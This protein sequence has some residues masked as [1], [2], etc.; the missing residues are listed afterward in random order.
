M[1]GRYPS[2][3]IELKRIARRDARVSSATTLV[4]PSLRS[5]P[6]ATSPALQHGVDK[7]SADAELAR[8]LADVPVAAEECLT[9]PAIV[10]SA[11]LPVQRSSWCSVEPQGREASG[12]PPRS[13]AVE[14]GEEA[15]LA[16]Q[17]HD[18]G[19][20]LRWD[21]DAQDGT[22]TFR[23]S[24]IEGDHPV[25]CNRLCDD[26]ARDG[27]R[28]RFVR[29]PI[30]VVAPRERRLLAGADHLDVRDARAGDLD[31]QSQGI[32]EQRELSCMTIDLQESLI[33]A[34]DRGGLLET[35]NSPYLWHRGR[36]SRLRELPVV[37][38]LDPRADLHDLPEVAKI[39]TSASQRAPAI[40]QNA[41]AIDVSSHRRVFASTPAASR[42]REHSGAEL[43][44]TPS[45]TRA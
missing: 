30:E 6:S 31:D 25:P 36:L 24:S 32:I 11:R 43:A 15:R 38:I 8:R 39:R 26:V 44:L 12:E 34:L 35:R 18:P 27:C 3:S 7:R 23:C 19:H 14:V 45:V 5:V 4:L 40:D 33:E 29:A 1:L 37:R 17:P 2:G 42:S 41:A 20:H 22:P 16:L 13:L 9:N 28:D 21:R 10:E